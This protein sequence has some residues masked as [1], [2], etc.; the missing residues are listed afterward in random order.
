MTQTVQ[1]ALQ[2]AALYSDDNFYIMVQLPT[3]A[4]TAAAGVLAEV[5]EAFSVLIVDKDEV[6][7]I[8]PAEALEEFARRLPNYQSSVGRYRL[9]TFDAV[10]EPTLVGF[11]AHVSQALAAAGVAIFAF[12]AYSR[13]HLLVP[14][15]LYDTA[16]GA[17]EN[18]K[19]SS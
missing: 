5:G 4:I 12:A 11:L 17:L 3:N 16:L 10:L 2:Q 9:I 18:L 6:T 15:D 7:L 14:A 8:L 19:E 1:Q 13:D